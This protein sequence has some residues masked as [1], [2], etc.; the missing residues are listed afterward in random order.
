MSTGQSNSRKPAAVRGRAGRRHPRRGAVTLLAVWVLVIFLLIAAWV[1]NY[2]FLVLVN[3]N[4][5]QKSDAVAL[6]AAAALLDEDLLRDYPSPPVPDQTDDFA[7]AQDVAQQ[8]RRLNNRAQSAA[9]WLHPG[10]MVVESGFV[11]DVTGGSPYRFDRSI[12]LDAPDPPHNTLHV[13]CRR[14]AEGNHPVRYILDLFHGNGPRAVDVLGGA[15]A[16]LDNLLIGFRPTATARSPVMPMAVDASAWVSE[17]ATGGD[18]NANN[19]REM[20]LR[21]DSP[22][23]DPTADENAVLIFYDGTID[24]SVLATQIAG[25]LTAG[26]LPP[27]GVLGP[28]T[29]KA[30][31]WAAAVRQVD[32]AAYPGLNDDLAHLI[33]KLST[34]GEMKRVFPLYDTFTDPSQQA[35]AARLVGFVAARILDAVVED[36]RL[37][38]SVEPCFVIHSTCWTTSPDHPAEPERNIYIHKL[39]LTH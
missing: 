8:Y 6:A 23:D 16:T 19:V 13:C 10:D 26:D 28:V 38:V 29:P 4:M 7:Q 36:D 11:S 14:P 24:V 9:F 31:L 20:V 32:T 1:L 27:E 3:R 39:R 37:T 17:R 2:N 35:G 18:A 30:P 33:D 21:L 34:A 5:Q 22:N 15:Y 25:G 12:P